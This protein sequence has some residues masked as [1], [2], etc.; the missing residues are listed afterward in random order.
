MDIIIGKQ[1][2]QKMP[3][4]DP[5]VSRK[6]CKVT[7]NS[8]GTYTIANLSTTSFTKVDGRDII[9][10]Q[11]TLDS[12][13]QLGPIFK[14]RLRDL[15]D[16]PKENPRQKEFSISHLEKIWEDYHEADLALKDKQHKMS[17]YQRI[18]VFFTIGAGALTSV[19]WSLGWG[20]WI[21]ILSICFTVTGFLLMI[22]F[23]KQASKFNPARESDKLQQDFQNNYHCPNP[24]CH[25]FLG[26]YSYTIMKNQYKMSCPYCK[27]KYTENE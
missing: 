15:I 1:G 19:S 16:V 11:A 5:T 2:N 26:N 27:C 4:S 21:K 9:K 18:P 6:H 20:E 23:F 17:L 3:I 25:R 14:A 12:E 22:Y 7:V 8:D 24:E 13:I 10:T